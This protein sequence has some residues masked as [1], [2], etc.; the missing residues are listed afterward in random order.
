MKLFK[1]ENKKLLQN[2]SYYFIILMIIGLIIV[3]AFYFSPQ[4]SVDYMTFE[5]STSTDVFEH[6][7]LEIIP[8]VN[9][10]IENAESIV[11][12]YKTRTDPVTSL[13]LDIADLK[14]LIYQF[15]QNPTDENRE[16]L[17]S[18]YSS[19]INRFFYNAENTSLKKFLIKTSDYHDYKTYLID[20]QTAM[21]DVTNTTNQNLSDILENKNIIVTLTGLS[22]KIYNFNVSDTVIEKLTLDISIGKTYLS[23]KQNAIASLTDDDLDKLIN[24]VNE[25]V[26]YADTLCDYVYF[27]VLADGLSPYTDMQISKF[28]TTSNINLYE[29]KETVLKYDYLISNNKTKL[30]FSIVSPINVTSSYK[31]SVFD[32]AYV[33]TEICFIIIVFYLIFL[34]AYS[35]SG[36]YSRGTLKLLMIR[37]FRRYKILFSKIASIL[38]NS[39]IMVLLSYIVSLIVGS[40]FIPNSD[41]LPV[42]TVYNATNILITTQENIALI[43]LLS[44]IIEV[45]VIVLAFVTISVLI[46]REIYS[47]A[48]CSLITIITILMKKYFTKISLLIFLPNVNL[49]LFKYF[50][51]ASYVSES[52]FTFTTPPTLS[53]DINAAIVYIVAMIII[54]NVISFRKFKELDIK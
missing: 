2:P 35:I 11:N 53:F 16:N 23:E 24:Y 10:D 21:T 3:S 6:F 9:S 15:T 41:V 28:L 46:P 42:L 47:I 26:I 17:S 29:I 22:E 18:E 8:S 27:S 38:I 43:Y 4:K 51:G 25:Y 36:E 33:A 49:N 7:N 40:F 5:N 50:G 19:F 31:T 34:C 48:T 32:F 37:P 54:F 52:M 45:T 30:D 13:N 14:D 20:I 39:I 1:G 12:E 44:K